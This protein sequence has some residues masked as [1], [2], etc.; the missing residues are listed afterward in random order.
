[1][2]KTLLV[3]MLTLTALAADEKGPSGRWSG[4]VSDRKCGTNIDPDCNRR[5]LAS[6]EAPVL[7]V[8]G[9]GDVLSIANPEAL[10][11]YG[12]SHVTVTGT[13]D[14]KALTAR[15]VSVPRCKRSDPSGSFEGTAT[16]KEAG[17]LQIS[18][19]LAC[20]RD[21]YAGELLTPVGNYA[22]AG[23]SVQG[24]QVH[25]D[26]VGGGAVGTMDLRADAT[27]LQGSFR[28]SADTGPM[29]LHRVA[30]AKP[31]AT[32]PVAMN[33]T[34]A[35]WR[36]DLQYFARE[37]PKRHANAFHHVTREEFEKEVAALDARLDRLS[38]DEVYVGMDRIANLVGDGHTYIKFPPDTADL[39]LA[40]ARF[41]A[42]YRVAAVR[43]GLEK[44]LGARVVKIEDTPIARAAELTRQLTPQD[45]N[46][47]L[48]EAEAA[49]FLTMGIVL[50]GL[51]ITPDRSTVRYTLEDDQGQRSMLEVHAGANPGEWVLPFK[52]QRLRTQHRE[53]GFW[54]T[55]LAE[56]STVYCNFR[57]Y[58]ALDKST[59][60]LF[61]LVRQQHPEKVAIDLRQ[62]GGGDFH[63]GEKH[64][65]HPLRDLP[66]VNRKG[67]LF[68]LIGTYTFSAAM[69]NAAQFRSQTAA[70]LVGQAIGEKPNSYQEV[71][72]MTL[73]NSRL[74]VRYS[75]KF[76]KFV[77][78]GENAVRPDQEIA[79]TWEDYK[80]GRDPV[81]E[82][83]LGYQ[84][85][86]G[87]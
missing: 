66:E 83:V 17:Q 28:L 59:K 54:C 81:L 8:D 80:S 39:P 71:R 41:G 9:T 65:I 4:W 48:Q 16:S 55:Y 2:K 14:G 77:E 46:P 30:A 62:N 29:E 7:V 43:P 32:T 57:S 47:W 33:L 3:L 26:F 40:L 11:S 6:G 82:W 18:L 85:D 45:E 51:D 52:D 67:H 44:A 22:I 72:E 73:P 56:A 63:E 34:A 21:Q 38:P 87:R 20:S 79:P 23:G 78:S 12:G 24:G 10:R 70:L 27:S 31:T 60:Q 64:L 1:M 35:Q 42:D 74:V 13:L 5:C 49:Q 84:P 37:M 19:N 76:Y 61:E 50:H 36:A 58:H 25:L 75:T 68:V 15:S 53:E 69:S 86:A